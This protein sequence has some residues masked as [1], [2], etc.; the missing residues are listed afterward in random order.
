A[1][2]VHVR[3][4]QSG[5]RTVCVLLGDG[6]AGVR[7]PARHRNRLGLLELGLRATCWLIWVR[8]LLHAWA[9]WGWKAWTKRPLFGTTA[10]LLDAADPSRSSVAV[11]CTTC[12]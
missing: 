12:R 8:Q 1:V 3:R 6:E 5:K 4:I 10:R 2:C 9:G 7:E 11:R